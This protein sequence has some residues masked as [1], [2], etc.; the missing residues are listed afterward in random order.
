[1]R[2]LATLAFA[3]ISACTPPPGPDH[4]FRG[5]PILTVDANHRVVQAIAVR[6]NVITAVGTEAEVLATRTDHTEVHDLGGRTLMP[7]FVAAH[8]HPTLS[9]VFGGTVD[10][11]GFTRHSSTEVWGTVREAI[12]KTPKG[13]WVYA[14]GVDPILVPGLQMPTRRILDAIAPEHPLV[15]VAQTMHSYWANSKALAAAGLTRDTPDPGNGSFYGRDENGELT[16]FIAEGAAAKPLLTELR[17]PWRMIERYTETLDGL[18]EH[19]FTTVT[20]LGYTVPPLLA[21]YAASDRLKPR[22]RQFFFLAKDDLDYLPETPDRTNN[23]LRI[24]GVKLWHDGSPYTG[25]MVLQEPYLDTPLSQALGIAPN[26]RGEPVTPTAQ[27]AEEIRRYSAKGWPV[28]IHSQGDL[29][30]REV[31]HALAEVPDNP[32]LPPRRLEHCLLLPK[33]L[34]PRLASLRVSPSFHINHLYYYGDALADSLLGPE[35]TARI[36]PVKSAFDAGL[37]PTLHADSPM[38]PA[39]P[40][41]LMRTAILRQTRGGRVIGADEQLTIEQALEAMTINGAY[42]LGVDDRLGSLEVGK[43]A[44]FQVLTANPLDTPA[45]RLPDIRT[46]EVWMDGRRQSLHG[47]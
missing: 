27:L 30:S 41:S 33:S 31:I 11:S 45:P 18:L 19:G 44:D 24:Q 3:A 23:T 28:A 29:S 2:F 6:G 5:G 38:F 8:E 9:A 17:K 13:E 42:Q 10:V 1:M 21:R 22:I 12:A 25:S 14:M 36:L 26:S 39:E 4:I 47:R 37:R 16:G 20:S 15:M 34:M 35:R 7:G 46:I 43:L 32:D 40:F